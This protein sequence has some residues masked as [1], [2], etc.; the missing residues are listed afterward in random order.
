MRAI[1]GKSRAFLRKEIS[2]KLVKI[3]ADTKILSVEQD[4]PYLPV[5][6]TQIDLV[7]QRLLAI[8]SYYTSSQ[9]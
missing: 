8:Q 2:L 7:S 9:T 5:L 4:L 1:A 6:L 3:G